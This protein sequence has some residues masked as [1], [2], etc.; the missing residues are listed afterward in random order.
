MTVFNVSRSIIAGLA[1]TLA[2]AGVVNAGQI[3]TPILFLGGTTQLVCVA[4]NATSQSVTVTV[5]I[6]GNVGTSTDTCTLPASD[7]N[8]C[9]VFRNN[10]S[11]RCRIAVT[12]L[13]NNQ[14]R[15]RVRGV[16][17]TRVTTLP[18]RIGAVVQAQ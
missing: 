11:G 4:S 17:F 1:F 2:S 13:T 8:G 12:G 18:P 10:E 16:M 15:G 7:R 3:E 6:I 9:Q 14:V 5:S